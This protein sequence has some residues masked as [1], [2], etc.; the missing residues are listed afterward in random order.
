MELNNWI[1]TDDT[2]YFLKWSLLFSALFGIFSIIL[3][4]VSNLIMIRYIGIILGAISITLILLAIAFAFALPTHFKINK[5]SISLK[6]IKREIK[7]DFNIITKVQV[8][9]RN[10]NNSS[11]VKIFWNK[12][13]YFKMKLGEQ[14]FTSTSN[15]NKIFNYWKSICSVG[16]K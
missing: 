12:N 14:F 11:E 5:E 1:S 2:W 3:W 7:I 15:A 10:K 8:I 13:G 4:F 6:F 9:K 16:K